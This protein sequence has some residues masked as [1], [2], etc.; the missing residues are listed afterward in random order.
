VLRH[1][2]RLPAG[3]PPPRTSR[4]ARIARTALGLAAAIA[5]ALLPAVVAPSAAN[6]AMGDRPDFKLPF[7]CGQT[8]ELKTYYGHN[9]DDMKLDMYNTG[10][11]TNHA[12]VVASAGGVVHEWF[13]PGGIE[14]DHG[15]GWFT[16]YLHMDERVAVGTHVS[17]GD[18]VGKVGTAGTSVPHLHYEQLYDS[19]G[20]GDGETGEMVHPV[21]QGTEY[22][23]S[24]DGPFPQV[25]S[26]NACG[27]TPP[28]AKDDHGCAS[29]WVCY[30]PGAGWNGDAP[31]ASYYYYRAYNLSEQHGRHRIFNNQ[32]D[33]AKA[34]TCTGWNGSGTCTEIPAGQWVDRNIAPINSIK[35]AP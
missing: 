13:D 8:W 30:Y 12:D 11:E 1:H 25:T 34:Y 7:P 2:S 28:P 21:V 32:T 31:A 14:I 17:E 6:A 10:G 19:D 24:P 9:P 33:G 26:Q 4:P 3:G 20:N 22:S 18:W 29:G 23:L 16:V 27:S 35:L 15:N 5:A